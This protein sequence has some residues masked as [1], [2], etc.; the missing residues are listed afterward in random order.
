MSSE[1]ATSFA[2][3]GA[4]RAR[5]PARASR[6]P[7]RCVANAGH[8]PPS[9]A[10]PA[11][12]RRVAHQL[13]GSAVD[14][15]RHF[16]RLRERCARHGQHHEILD[17]DPPSRVRAAPEDLDLAAAAACTGLPAARWRHRGKPRAAA[18]ACATASD[19]ASGRIA[20]R[21]RLVRRSVEA[22]PMPRRCRP[23]RAHP[24]P[25]VRRGSGP[26][27]ARDGRVHVESAETR[28]AVAQV[29]RLARAARGAGR[30]IARPIAPHSSTTSAS[31]R[32]S[33]ARIP[34]APP[35]RA[36]NRLAHARSAGAGVLMRTRPRAIGAQFRQPLPRVRR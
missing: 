5:S 27:D 23:D 21:A 34:D 1:I 4:A 15:G 9:S 25:R 26:L 12:L 29:D 3:H 33:P 13:P 35:M 16:E 32:R 11:S 17:V 14:L 10:T 24:A 22:R 8:H 30:A 6:A 36:R 28:A 19:T 20:R 2:G 7:L 18:A 31:T